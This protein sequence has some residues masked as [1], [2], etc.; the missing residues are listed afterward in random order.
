MAARLRASAIP[1]SRALEEVEKRESNG[2]RQHRRSGPALRGVMEDSYEAASTRDVRFCRWSP[3]KPRPAFRRG[4]TLREELVKAR[5]SSG[6][7][8]RPR[9]A[10]RERL[11][12]VRRCSKGQGNIGGIS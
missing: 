8:A 10:A 1:C 9:A 5:L 2:E 3:N 4:K 6:R 7:V 12:G 11:E